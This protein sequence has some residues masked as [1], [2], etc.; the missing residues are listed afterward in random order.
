MNHASRLSFTLGGTLPLA[1]FMACAGSEGSSTPTASAGSTAAGSAGTP[2]SSGGTAGV[3]TG[4]GGAAAGAGG[5]S[6]TTNAGGGGT[7]AGG[8]SGGAGAGAMPAAGTGNAGGGSAGTGVVAGD[9]TFTVASQTADQ[10]GP[11]G[12]PTV[13]IVDW[14]VDLANLASAKLVFGPAGGAPTTSADIDVTQGPSFRS[15]LLGMKAEKTYAFHLE[16]SDGSKACSSAE[17]MITTGALPSGLPTIARTAGSAAASQAKGFIVTSTGVG[18]FGGMMGGG[19]MGGAGYAY[20]LDA[21]GE[22]VWFAPGPESCSRAKMSADGQ[23]MWMTEVNV[24]NRTK[25]GGEVRR[26]SMD[27]LTTTMKVPGLSNCHHDLTVLPDGKVACLSWIQQSGDQPSDLIESDELGNVTKIMTLDSKVYVGG[28]GGSSYHANSL[29]YHPKDDSYTIG[30][31][32]PNAYVKVSRQGQLLWQFGG[33]CSNAPAPQCVA[34]DWTVNH[35]HDLLDDGT[36]ILF[37][38]GQNGASAALFYK[39]TETGTFAAQKLDSYSPGTSSPVLGDVQ[40][41]PNGNTLVTFSS[42]AV[43][44]EIDPSGGLVQSIS[45]PGGYAEWRESLYG[46][47][48]RF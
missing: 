48:P 11:G 37:N 17:Y 34:G 31:R 41:L 45:G 1:F 36:F 30:D 10:A 29:H 21:D 18:M 14:S 4:S 9:C 38:N 6:G 43:M 13:G 19:M 15:L 42:G 16:V 46:A 32:N 20:I 26:V 27:G 22:L 12:I 33:S 7:P 40:R 23:F 25:D 28:G 47:P 8:S 44:H 3:T 24:D 2:A 5:A 39:L 35:G